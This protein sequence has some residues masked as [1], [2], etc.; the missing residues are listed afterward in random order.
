[1]LGGSECMVCGYSVGG[2]HPV[3][4]EG[5]GLWLCDFCHS[6]KAMSL[7]ELKERI[8]EELETL[9]RQ[10]GLIHP[11]DYVTRIRRVMFDKII[12]LERKEHERDTN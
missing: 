8:N 11:T 3:G 4:E 12:Y 5:A 1:M 7:E 6:A 10:M 2:M 9:A